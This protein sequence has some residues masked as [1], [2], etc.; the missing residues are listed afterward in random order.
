MHDFKTVKFLGSIFT[1]DFNISNY[2]KIANT[3]V[4][5]LGD[6]LDGPPNIMRIPQS[7]PSEIPRIMLSS[8]DKKVNVNI[9]LSRTN[10]F[11]EVMPRIDS[12]GIDINE[13]SSTSSLFFS[14]FQK[15]LDLRVQRMGFVTERVK[16]RKDALA[17]IQERFCNKDQIEKGRPF[18]NA[19]R[20]EIHSLKNYPWQNFNINS[21]VR[22]KYIPIL[23]DDRSK[24]EPVLL[25]E[26]DLNT[27]SIEDDEG[28]KFTDGDIRSFFDKAHVEIEEILNLYFT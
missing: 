8:S 28:A 26:N 3:A 13:Y 27:L 23:M 1:P 14:E 5:I 6:K 2:L 10:L 11:S 15:K 9:S 20:F 19:K 22:V 24:I 7:A 18:N 21:W 16:F 17:Y 12:E 4:E 25:V